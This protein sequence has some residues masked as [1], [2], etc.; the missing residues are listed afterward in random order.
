MLL[1]FATWRPGRQFLVTNEK[2][3]LALNTDSKLSH[4]DTITYT[5]VTESTS[6]AGQIIAAV[7]F[8]DSHGSKFSYITNAS[9]KALEDRV[10]FSLPYA[11][12]LKLLDYC[13]N[14]LKGREVYILTNLRVD[15]NGETTSG[16]HFIPV[17][18]MDVLPGDDS[19]PLIVKFTTQEG[20]IESVRMTVA[21]ERHA[22]RN[23][24]TLFS[25]TD[26][27]LQY[28]AITDAT[29]LKI[30]DGTVVE[31]MT[32][33]EVRLSIG[34]PVDITKDNKTITETER[35]SY[36]DGRSLLFE[37]GIL[38]KSHL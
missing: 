2:I 13:T 6:V 23:F 30:V 12:D 24:F 8:T 27:R 5:D 3:R 1:P 18:I 11:I 19:A 36:P 22:T 20:E 25:F 15:D 10:E 21:D 32:R 9:A 28:P 38:I 31:G 16:K 34:A 14:K 17:T 33:D 7:N 37:N 29:W 4:G 26:P 35:W